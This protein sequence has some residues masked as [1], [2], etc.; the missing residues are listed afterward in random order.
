MLVKIS[1]EV[2][3]ALKNN[4]PVVALE[5]TIISHGMPY[6]INVETALNNL[7]TKCIQ[8]TINKMNSSMGTLRDWLNSAWVG[9]SADQFKKNMETDKEK[10]AEALRTTYDVL[11]SEMYQIVNEMAA[12]DAELVK[13]RAE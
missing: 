2:Q 12:A 13:G 6:P 5:S 3:E 7:N 4:I 9:A 8:D 11:K 10:I 1:Q